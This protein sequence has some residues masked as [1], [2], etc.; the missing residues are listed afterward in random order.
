M[1]WEGYLWWMQF[2]RI[3]GRYATIFVSREYPL[4]ETEIDGYEPLDEWVR[5][6]LDRPE[7]PEYNALYSRYGRLWIE[8][9]NN[10]DAR[11]LLGRG[12]LVH[13][14]WEQGAH[15]EL[16]LLKHDDGVIPEQI[17]SYFC[18]EFASL[19]DELL[20]RYDAY[21]VSPQQVRVVF[22]PCLKPSIAAYILWYMTR[23][24]CAVAIDEAHRE[25]RLFIARLQKQIEAWIRS[26]EDATP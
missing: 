12:Y 6:T 20:Y 4:P 17:P 15:H 9:L 11:A 2:E 10:P 16:V 23:E 18:F 14:A 1:T 24:A 7:D 21:G 22:E 26:F 25:E 3:L 5:R 19:D 8:P 13:R